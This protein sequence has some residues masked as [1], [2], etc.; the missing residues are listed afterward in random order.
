[1]YRATC[2]GCPIVSFPFFTPRQFPRCLYQEAFTLYFIK[3]NSLAMSLK[4][5][6]QK[7]IQRPGTSQLSCCHTEGIIS[8]LSRFNLGPSDWSRKKVKSCL[9]CSHENKSRKRESP[10]IEPSVF[11]SKSTKY[12]LQDWCVLLVVTV[13][14]VCLYVCLH[15]PLALGKS[16]RG[17]HSLT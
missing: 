1:M 12:E 13:M 16:G 11:S 14:C 3:I 5:N 2:R 4:K 6:K 17:E 8:F 7:K 10:I 9:Q 15:T